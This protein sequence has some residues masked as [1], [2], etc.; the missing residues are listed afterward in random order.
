MTQTRLWI[1]LLTLVAFLAGTGS[2]LFLAERGARQERLQTEFGE[3]ERAFVSEFSLDPD[4]Q[5]LLA[6]LLD[7]YNREKQQ[8]KDHYA[9]L[10]LQ[11]MEPDLRRVGLEYRS[12]LRDRLLPESQRPK[13][14]RL[15]ATFAEN[16]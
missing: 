4:R 10:N 14:D 15:V 1:L 8:I 7:H 6:G 5:R 13:F 16:L 12:H 2:G 9:S 3:F 11:E